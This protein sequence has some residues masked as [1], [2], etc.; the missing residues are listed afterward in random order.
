VIGA[1][2]RRDAKIGA[3]KRCANFCDKFLHCIT[4]IGKTLAA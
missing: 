4:R 2:F 3:Q 1:G